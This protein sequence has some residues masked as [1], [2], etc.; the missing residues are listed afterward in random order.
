MSPEMQNALKALR[1][2]IVREHPN[3]VEATVTFMSGGRASIDIEERSE[4]TL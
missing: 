3:T 2:V 1:D 4:K